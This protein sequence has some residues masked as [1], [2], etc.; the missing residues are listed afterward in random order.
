MEAL[1]EA[2]RL[3]AVDYS[4]SVINGVPSLHAR[5]FTKNHH[6]KDIIF[7]PAD[8]GYYKVQWDVVVP[9]D[10]EA[11]FWLVKEQSQ[12]LKVVSVYVPPQ[13]DIPRLLIKS[14]SIFG[15]NSMQRIESMFEAYLA[16]KKKSL[17]VK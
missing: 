1:K 10:V 11:G 17:S 8:T 13:A 16:T 5:V 12:N 7:V 14:E 2:N 9:E 15:S 3:S 6:F 4:T